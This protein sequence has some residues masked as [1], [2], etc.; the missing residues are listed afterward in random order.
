MAGERKQQILETLAKM[1]ESP[2]REKITTASLA[3]K[4]EVSE[5][6][7]Y[8]HFANKAQM[9][10]GLILFIE[11]TIFGLINKISAEEPEGLRQIQ[12]I[13]TMLMVFAEKNSGMTRVLIGDALVNEDDKL[14][15]RINQLYDRIEVTL[16]QCLRIAETQ[17]G[18]KHDAEAQA[19]LIIC[20]IIGRWNQYAKSG[21][22][23]KPTEFIEQQLP[24]LL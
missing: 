6:A 3:S 10:E 17:T 12:R 22:K 14:Q 21:F 7:L 18:H 15:L 4:L 1:L 19:N 16:K 9:F 11:E 2:K 13:V 23:R 20:Y 8:R 5:A 24:N